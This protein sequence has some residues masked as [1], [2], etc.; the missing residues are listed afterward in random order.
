[1]L[2]PEFK[3]DTRAFES[4]LKEYIKVSSRTAVEVV[5]GAAIEVIL[6]A[7]KRTKVANPDHI[8][9]GLIARIASV[10]HSPKT[11]K[12]YKKPRMY[13]AYSL[14]AYK[15]INSRLK[16]AGKPRIAGNAMSVA[17]KRMLGARLKAV[18]YIARV[19]WNNALRDLGSHRSAV[20]VFAKSLAAKGSG[21]KATEHLIYAYMSN[22][23]KGA[24]V[25]AS[26]PFQDA[27]NAK[28]ENMVRR[29][30]DKIMSKGRELIG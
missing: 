12:R 9:K 21:R 16:K 18:G 10:T 17:V 28:A 1:M 26:G 11:G 3:L 20:R 13:P 7:Q 2:A 25:V 8:K 14:L 15:I 6:Q 5:N 29:A 22:T 4:A 27:I 23:A 30:H 24:L 19:G